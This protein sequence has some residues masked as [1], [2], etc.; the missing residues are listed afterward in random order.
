MGDERIKAEKIVLTLC[1]EFTMK[2][3][4]QNSLKETHFKTW[5]FAWYELPSKCILHANTFS[6][7]IEMDC[8]SRA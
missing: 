8:V 4:V 1:R 2:I 3:I 6:Y 7:F 5:G